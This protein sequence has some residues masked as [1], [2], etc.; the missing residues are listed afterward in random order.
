MSKRNPN[1]EQSICWRRCLIFQTQLQ[2]RIKGVG[3]GG[4]TLSVR[5]KFGV[6]FGVPNANFL[7]INFH[8]FSAAGENFEN[9]EAQES[10]NQ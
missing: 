10:R 8:I 5:Q 7:Y 9:F 3:F 1:K 6:H 4:L 2:G